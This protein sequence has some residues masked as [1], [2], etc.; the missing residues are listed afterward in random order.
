MGFLKKFFGG[1]S[2]DDERKEADALF[3]GKDYEEARIVYERA[4][5][6]KK[7]APADAIEHCEERVGACLDRMAE[8]RIEEAERLLEAGHD[9]LAETELKNA[10]ETASSPEIAKRAERML[11]RFEAADAKQRA[12]MPTE[13][14]DDD[15]WAL[16]MSHWEPDQGDEYEEYE[17]DLR[18]A[19]LLLDEGKADEALE[20]LEEIL[21]DA[22]DPVYLWLEIGRAR[23]N[24]ALAKAPVE[25]DEPKPPPESLAPAEEALRKFLEHMEDDEGGN[26]QLG[27]RAD[28]AAIRDLC[29]DEEGAI[30]ELEAAMDAFPDDT[31]PFYLMGRY[32]SRKGHAESA[33]EVL[34]AGVEM[35]DEDRP[36]WRYLEE[37]GIACVEAEEEEK[38]AMYLDRVIGLFVA[39]RRLDA[40]PELPSRTGVARAKLHEEAGELEKA[41]DLYRTLARGPDRA[42]HLE[43]HLEAARVLK[44]LE[45]DDEAKR[46]LTRAL[47]LAENA[48]AEKRADIEAKLAELD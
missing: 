36:D 16:L 28:L 24:A 12:S 31:R 23:L 46:M 33:V 26:A 15:R 3:D 17:D 20:L 30:A 34:E 10:I 29:G 38:A 18:D 25:N 40:E 7:G 32:L 6:K 42:R 48:P 35:L 14:T 4:L 45:L 44:E 13:L 5:D 21:E 2:F 43:F 27:A 47:A 19:L 1:A 39:I 11:E 9:D 41:A 8:L 37:L 22:E